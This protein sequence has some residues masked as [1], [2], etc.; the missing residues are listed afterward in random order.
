MTAPGQNYTP[1]VGDTLT[2]LGEPRP[3][4]TRRQRVVTA[5]DAH[6][7]MDVETTSF[8]GYVLVAECT[9]GEW[10]E[11]VAHPAS[12]RLDAPRAVETPAG[13]ALAA[14]YA[15]ARR[16]VRALGTVLK[17]YGADPGLHRTGLTWEYDGYFTW[18]GGDGYV[19]DDGLTL[20]YQSTV[21]WAEPHMATAEAYR[22]WV[23]QGEARARAEADAREMERVRLALGRLYGAAGVAALDALARGGA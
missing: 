18:D 19:S 7:R 5:P 20:P 1:Q 4:Y 21:L 2:W 16:A 12:W 17:D 14:A 15:D 23:A 9:V 6:A 8:T 22:A 13:G 3:V 10:L 11:D